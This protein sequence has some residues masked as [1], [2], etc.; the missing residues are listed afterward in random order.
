MGDDCER[1]GSII[2]L[3]AKILYKQDA[4]K[5]KK[6]NVAWHFVQFIWLFVSWVVARS[7]ERR[8]GKILERKLCC[9]VRRG[10]EP[11]LAAAPGRCLP[12]ANLMQASNHLHRS[13]PLFTTLH[14]LI[15]VQG[16]SSAEL[17]IPRA[18]PATTTTTHPS[19]PADLLALSIQHFC[20]RTKGNGPTNDQ[21]IIP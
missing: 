11:R 19:R 9:A 10:A 3:N 13:P 12:A 21:F 1:V 18:F 20:F 2:T 5:F 6:K 17:R 14:H 16:W 15:R 7:N 8:G 4:F